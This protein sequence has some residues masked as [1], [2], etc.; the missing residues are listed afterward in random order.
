MGLPAVEAVS[1][2]FVNFVFG[3]SVRELY[4]RRSNGS[5]VKCSI[6]MVRAEKFCME[7][8]V[9]TAGEHRHGEI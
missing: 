7:R 6:R 5:A 1:D 3:M 8:V 9:N 2:D 4:W